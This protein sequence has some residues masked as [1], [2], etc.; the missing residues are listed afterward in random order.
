LD[1]RSQSGTASGPLPKFPNI[2]NDDD[3]SQS[4]DP[5]AA[6][7]LSG[8]KCS[9][10]YKIHLCTPIESLA[11]IEDGAAVFAQHWQSIC[12]SPSACA[13]RMHQCIV[14]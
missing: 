6:A 7:T 4:D 11:A 2:Q 8:S 14:A 3:E 10:I 9:N 12:L 5:V 13:G 1:A